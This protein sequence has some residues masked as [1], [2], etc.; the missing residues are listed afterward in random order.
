MITG[1]HEAQLIQCIGELDRGLTVLKAELRQGDFVASRNTAKLL[2]VLVQIADQT[3]KTAGRMN[4]KAPGDDPGS[5]ES[6]G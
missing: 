6:P 3:I 2:E 1:E 5:A 4:A